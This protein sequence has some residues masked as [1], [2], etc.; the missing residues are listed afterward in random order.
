MSNF[1]LEEIKP[2]LISLGFGFYGDPSDKPADPERTIIEIISLFTRDPKMFR[3]LLAWFE[4]CHDL[5]H[6]ER[7][8]SFAD[9]LSGFELR[10][11]GALSMKQV[12]NC[13]R[14]F[15]MIAEFAKN[16]LKTKKKD[17]SSSTVEGDD[18]Y[19]IDKLG[20]DEE[21]KEFGL[22][23][24]KV[25][26]THSKKILTLEEILRRNAWLRFRALIGAN[27]RAD[28]AFVMANKQAQNPYQAAKILGCSQETAYRLWKGLIMYP[29]MDKLAG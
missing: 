9:G 28:L 13:D 11:L 22:R 18:P 7:L 12:K 25:E 5:V 16:E 1:K 14:R 15:S 17:G 27:F 21:F 19:L 10:I 24:A 6:V 23:S 29:S 20:I 8:R 4:K 3:M 26:P 2:R